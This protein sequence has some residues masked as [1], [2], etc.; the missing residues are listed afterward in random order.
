V[1]ERVDHLLDDFVVRFRRGEEPNLREY[2]VR[3]ESGAEELARLV[4]VFLESVP[5]PAASDERLALSRAWAE[6]EAPLLALRTARGLRRTEI[7]SALVSQLGIDVKKE[8]KLRLRYHELETGQLEAA[9]VDRR[10]WE[11]LGELLKARIEDLAAWTRPPAPAAP[12]LVFYRAAESAPVG[13]AEWVPEEQFDEI[14]E[15]FGV[16][17]PAH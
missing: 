14:D 11:V 1:S 16:G 13:P 12:R 15:L 3:A 6:A 5:P 17:R 8:E 4:D 7:V 2:L 10:V 9:G